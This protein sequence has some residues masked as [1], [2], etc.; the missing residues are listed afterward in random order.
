MFNTK[1]TRILCTTFS[2]LMASESHMNVPAI[3]SIR[4]KVE[5]F[6]CQMYCI[7]K[8]RHDQLKNTS[9]LAVSDTFA[10][11]FGI[12]S[13]QLEHGVQLLRVLIQRIPRR[14]SVDDLS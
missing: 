5:C 6:L 1:Y 8:I 10:I 12:I 9:R 13:E 11:G 14:S 4:S 2:E 7:A 3:S